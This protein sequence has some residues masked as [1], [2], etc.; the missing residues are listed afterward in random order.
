VAVIV[1]SDDRVRRSVIQKWATIE[2][3]DDLVDPAVTPHPIGG[4][5]DAP[6]EIVDIAAPRS[7]FRLSSFRSAAVTASVM[8]CLRQ[9][10]NSRASFSVFGVLDVERH[11]RLFFLTFLFLPEAT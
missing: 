3:I 1:V 6:V 9:C 8:P 7:R 2:P 10:A 11:A 4:L 5:L